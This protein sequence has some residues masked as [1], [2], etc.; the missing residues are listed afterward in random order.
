MW[1]NTAQ[2][3]ANRR[4]G[5]CQ[6]CHLTNDI[7]KFDS[8]FNASHLN[9]KTETD[10]TNLLSLEPVNPNCAMEAKAGTCSSDPVYM[11]TICDQSICGMVT[12]YS[13]IKYTLK[14]SN[15]HI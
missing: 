8:V 7:E 15:F 12:V 13:I 11:N 1:L 14:T 10:R 9:T 6:V 4:T 3:L 2:F 5:H